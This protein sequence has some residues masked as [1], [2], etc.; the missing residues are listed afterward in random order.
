M[1]RRLLWIG[2]WEVVFFFAP[3]GYDDEAVLTALYDA[4]APLDV[5][6]RANRIMESGRFN[7]GFTYTNL[8][9]RRAIVVVGPTTSGRQFQ[10]TLVHEIRHLADGIAASLGVSLS[11]E[12]PAYASGDAMMALA[13]V[14]CRLGCGMATCQ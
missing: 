14:V 4:D 10:N 2:R 7:R 13:D 5:M 12:A 8:E 1:I 3:D 9:N 6:A 11:S